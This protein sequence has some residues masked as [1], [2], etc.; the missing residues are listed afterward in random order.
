MPAIMLEK[1]AAPVKAAP[2]AKA[3]APVRVVV[4]RNYLAMTPARYA[5]RPIGGSNTEAVENLVITSASVED[6]FGDGDFRVEASF[7]CG[8]VMVGIE[9][10]PAPVPEDAVKLRFTGNSFAVVAGK[11]YDVQTA[12]AVY[13]TPDGIFAV[14]P[15]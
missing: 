3:P 4:T 9:A 7:G 13:F 6:A 2:K 1:P 8:V 11:N 5:M 12:A 14:K 15:K 10:P